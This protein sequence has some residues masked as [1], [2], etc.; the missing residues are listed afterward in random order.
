[1]SERMSI[2]IQRN[3]NELFKDFQIQKIKSM[4]KDNLI[5]ELQNHGY[6]Y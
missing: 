1:M 2:P 4:S 5:V 3:Y 6:M